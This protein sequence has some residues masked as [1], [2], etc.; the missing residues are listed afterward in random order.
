[1]ADDARSKAGDARTAG[2]SID[3]TA[4]TY[5]TENDVPHAEG[6]TYAVTDRALAETL[7]AIG[8]VSIAGWTDA[9][10]GGGAAP[11]LTTLTP[12]TAIVGAAAFT[13]QVAGSG[14]VAADVVTWNGAAVPTTFVSATELTAAID[15]VAAAGDI[16]VTVGASNALTFT[17]TAAR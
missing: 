14:F 5:H 7:R 3:M 12:A 1:M 10:S 13:V 11:V 2:E 6:E 16:A 8:F 9:G 4:R 15:A 17:V